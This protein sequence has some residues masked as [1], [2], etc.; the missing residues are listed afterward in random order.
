[1]SSRARPRAAAL[2]VL[3]ALGLTSV[4]TGGLTGVGSAAPADPAAA[5]GTRTQTLSATSTCPFTSGPRK[6]TVETSATFPTQLKT[7]ATATID[8]FSAKLVLP[9][10]AAL[11]LLPAGAATGTLQGGLRLDLAVRQDK[12][13]EK[14]PVPLTVAPTTLPETGDVTLVATG[15]VP[16]IALNAVGPVTFDVT[17]PTLALGPPPAE[18]ETAKPA[19][20]IACTLDP[21]QKTTLSTVMVVPPKQAAAK[22]GTNAVSAEDEGDP[23]IVVTSPLTLVRI[24]TTST[25]R[26]L[27]A[28]VASPPGFIINGT[29]TVRITPDTGELID[30]TVSGSAAFKP[31]TSVFLGFGFVPV[32]AQ[33]EFLPVDYRN[34]KMIDITGA[35]TTDANGVSFLTSHLRVMAR[36]SGAKVN[37]VPLDLGD[38]CVPAK[39]IDI[40]VT[41]P[42]DPFGVGHIGTDPNSPD[43]KFRGFTLPPFKNCGTG[44]EQLS[45]LLTGMSSGPGNQVMVDT[46]N[47]LECHEPDHTHCPPGS[48]EPPLPT[49]AAKKTSTRAGK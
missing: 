3:T 16:A 13:D 15:E 18:G 28:K 24:V 1:M 46:F 38:D 41:G 20:Q 34:S 48:T 4:V 27:G 22:P 11:A 44:G 26:R 6:V 29:L 12:R 36:L 14:V 5:P 8:G 17:A 49:A 21:D 32:S 9:R 37:G 19:T 30:T 47:L 7:N 35:L 40:D 33:V 2:A 39:P 10:E 25:V 23:P 45:P 42:Y 31:V 43:P